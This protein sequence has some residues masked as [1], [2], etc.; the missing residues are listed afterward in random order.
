MRAF[1]A[2]ALVL[3]ALVA[4]GWWIWGRQASPAGEIGTVIET[5]RSGDTVITLSGPDGG[6]RAGS[7]RFRI[8]FRSAATGEPIDAGVV[9]LGASM[10]MPGMVMNSPITIEPAGQPGAYDATGDFGMSGSW[11]MTIEWNGPAGRGSAAFEGNVQ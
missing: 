2:S 9:Q 7:N 10:Q 8:A 5:V 3:V 4:A 6:L 1:V 11:Q